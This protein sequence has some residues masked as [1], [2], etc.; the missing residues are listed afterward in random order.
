[1]LSGLEDYFFDLFLTMHKVF[2][3]CAIWC[4]L[5]LARRGARKGARRGENM[6][7][8]GTLCPG[9]LVINEQAR[10]YASS[11]GPIQRTPSEPA[12]AAIAKG[13]NR[14]KTPNAI[15]A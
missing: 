13:R 4:G 2:F 3:C 10:D 6:R 9:G 15:I 5:L 8:H 12:Y 7:E 11:W 14:G 1:M